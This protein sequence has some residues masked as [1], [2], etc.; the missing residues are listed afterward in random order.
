M[1]VTETASGSSRARTAIA[2]L[3]RSLSEQREA[4]TAPGLVNEAV[5]DGAPV[6]G[7]VSC[8]HPSGCALPSVAPELEVERLRRERDAAV[9]QEQ[10]A[11]RRERDAAVAEAQRRSSE[12]QSAAAE[13]AALREAHAVAALLQ[14]KHAAA[15]SSEDVARKAAALERALAANAE[16]AAAGAQQKLRIEAL[17]TKQAVL[18]ECFQAVEA[19][20]L[21]LRTHRASGAGHRQAPLLQLPAPLP[22]DQRPAADSNKLAMRPGANLMWARDENGHG[23]DPLPPGSLMAMAA[24]CAEL[25]YQL[26]QQ[27]RQADAARKAAVAA[28]EQAAGLRLLLARQAGVC[29]SGGSGPVASTE[30]VGR[31]LEA[32]CEQLEEAKR[33]E[34]E[35][36]QLLTQARGGQ[37]ME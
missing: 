3:L 12:L 9:Q 6:T 5:T 33:V 18:L 30:A 19:E 17:E 4:V 10:A 37:G 13:L 22:A 23:S 28:E 26:A 32:A 7:S 35:L 11:L 24:R 36:R 14:A 16:L 25:Q 20:L 34:V 21:Q 2:S 31:R 27:Q 15:S 8:A 29:G 1:R